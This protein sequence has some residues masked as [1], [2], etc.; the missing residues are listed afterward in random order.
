MLCLVAVEE[1]ERFPFVVY[2]AYVAHIGKTS[3]FGGVPITYVD[4]TSYARGKQT[5]FPC[6]DNEAKGM[7]QVLDIFYAKM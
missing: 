3:Q 7:W 1:H 5:L 2:L 4:A 6:A